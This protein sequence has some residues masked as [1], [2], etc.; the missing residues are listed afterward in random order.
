MFLEE[1]GTKFLS[2][3]LFAMFARIFQRRQL[4]DVIAQELN[5]A[6]T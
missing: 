5:V 6:K 2:K 4:K 3:K 1:P